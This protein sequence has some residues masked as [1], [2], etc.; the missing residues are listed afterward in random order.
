MQET[1]NAK[2]SGAMDCLAKIVAKEGKLG[3]FVGIRTTIFRETFC[4]A[5]QFAAFDSSKKFFST[6]RGIP[7]DKLPFIDNFISG[8]IAGLVCWIVSY[9]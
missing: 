1:V 7:R 3:L 9:P 2:Y 4:I 5:G 6:L 8:G